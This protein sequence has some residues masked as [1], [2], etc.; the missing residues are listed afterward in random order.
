MVPSSPLAEDPYASQLK[1]FYDV[2]VNGAEPRVTPQDGLA[3]VQI[4]LAAIESVASGRQVNIAEV[5]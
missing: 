4:A 1:H 3:A 2:I 5:Q